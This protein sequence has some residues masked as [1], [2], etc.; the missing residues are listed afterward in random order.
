MLNALARTLGTPNTNIVAV[1][2]VVQEKRGL[3]AEDRDGFMGFVGE[4]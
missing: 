2:L 3:V 4:A 1:Y